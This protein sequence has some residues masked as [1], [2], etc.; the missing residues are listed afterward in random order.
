MRNFIT[1]SLDQAKKYK[2]DR[3]YSINKEKRDADRFL[4]GKPEGKT[5]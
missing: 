3:A 5:H 1:C 4:V 2:T